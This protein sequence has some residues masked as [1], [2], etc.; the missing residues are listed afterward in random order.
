[1]TDSAADSPV[2]PA[3]APPV[4][5]VQ[6]R[7]PA[8]VIVI[9][10]GFA[11]A[12]F[13]G[14]SWWAQRSSLAEQLGAQDESLARLA[15]QTGAL[16]SQ[17]VEA[18]TRLADLS[19][20][21]DRNGRD[22]A[23]LQARIDDSVA[24][25]GRISEELSGGRTRFQLAA[26][27]QLLLLA[28]DRLQLQ[29]DVKSALAA[30]DMADARLARF[31][32]PQLFAVRE[33]LAQERAALR[34]VPVADLTSATLNLASLIARAPALPLASHAPAQ[35][36]SPSARE[37]ASAGDPAG[38]GWQRV[39][40]AVQATA[41]SLFTI[42]REDN[43]RAMRMLPPEAEAVVY[44][45]LILR[46]EGAR[47][48]L[49]GGNTVAMRE[50]LRSAADWLATEFKSDDPGVLATRAELDR[51]QGLELAPPLPD[52]SRS[53]AALRARLAAGDGANP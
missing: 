10:L 35:F 33:A 40:Q 19:R 23:A 3:A 2:P 29:H 47:V 43:T 12:I 26:V 41:R 49:L 25:L 39:L 7:G 16:E 34:A 38:A 13:G 17:S 14:W 21:S 8:L 5:R 6:W 20:L 22:I 44:D 48:A 50:Q 31:S 42:R 32:D 51:L 28:N 36:A 45:L 37:S 53:L 9:V 11:A 18:A 24:L 30:L 4:A 1:M 46:L 52:I 15:R 27:E